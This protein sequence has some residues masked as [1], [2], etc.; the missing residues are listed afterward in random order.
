[1]PEP[2]KPLN[3]CRAC[4]QDFNGLTLFDKHRVGKHEYTALEGM[5]M[6]P[7][8]RDGRRCLT[9]TEM[10]LKGWEPNKYGRWVN[11]TSDHPFAGV[12]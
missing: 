4:D 8:R 5:A 10:K 9:E 12:R 11:A 3:Y 1:M 7:P 6:T 2:R